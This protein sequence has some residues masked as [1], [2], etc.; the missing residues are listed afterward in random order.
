MT[1]PASSPGDTLRGIRSKI[2]AVVLFA[3]MDA[4]V[5]GLDGAYPTMQVMLFRT[6]FGFLPLL[7]AI[8]LAGG[9][10]SVRSRQPG[11]QALRTAI[12]FCALF[13]FFWAFPRMPL[14]DVYA[15]AYAAPIM[16]VALSVPLLGES[17]GWRRWTAVAV[18]FAG[19]VIVLDPRGGFDLVA[20]VVLGAT[21]LYALSMVCVRLLSRTD[22]DNAT[23]FWFALA[24]GAVSAVAVV[25]DPATHW[26]TPDAAG[27]AWLAAIGVVGGLGQIFIT[28]AFRL[29]PAS[30]LAPFE[31]SSIVFAFAFGW[32]F[33]AEIPGL[34]VLLG[35]PLVIGSGLYILHR[36]RVRARVAAAAVPAAGHEP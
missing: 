8:W 31:Y 10:A 11:L 16:M 33:F 26:R 4:A 13:G 18:G 15:I 20:W 3:G 19:V 12:G 5:K 35:L 23:M 21:F 1:S 14:V 27:F 9:F 25:A 32:L 30:V 24:V 29:A 22:H 2:L 36:E 17:V 28:R 34:S 7:V 6:V